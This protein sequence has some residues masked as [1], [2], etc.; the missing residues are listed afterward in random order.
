MSDHIKQQIKAKMQ[1][2][3]RLEA[4]IQECTTRLEIAGIRPQDKLV[5]REVS[6][7]MHHLT[8]YTKRHISC[9]VS[10]PTRS[11]R[12]FPE[13]TLMSQL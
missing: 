9:G 7:F 10:S 5:D 12:D 13:E 1:E 8:T 6:S 4:K 2:R 11:C 3:D